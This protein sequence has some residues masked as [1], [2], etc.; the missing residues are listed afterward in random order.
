MIHPIPPCPIPFYS[1]PHNSQVT[2]K[3]HFENPHSAPA[4]STSSSNQV[5]VKLHFPPVTHFQTP[6]TAPTGPE[7]QLGLDPFGGYC[8]PSASTFGSQVQRSSAGTLSITEG[9]C[10]PQP[11]QVA[12]WHV[13]QVAFIHIFA[14]LRCVLE[15]FGEKVKRV[16]D[17]KLRLLVLSG[18]WM[19]GCL[20]V[21]LAWFDFD[22]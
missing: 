17:L 13:E 7:S 1:S 14:F 15:G 9:M 16:V 3:S 11:H 19:S 6:P 4:T 12:F 22:E 8:L 20:V 2:T 18:S 10:L 21:W 5:V